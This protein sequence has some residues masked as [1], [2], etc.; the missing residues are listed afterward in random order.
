[1]LARQQAVIEDF[2]LTQKLSPG[3]V[4]HRIGWVGPSRGLLWLSGPGGSCCCRLPLRP[5][6]PLQDGDAGGADTP[7]PPLQVVEPELLAAAGRAEHLTTGTT[8]VPSLQMQIT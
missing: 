1:M 6:Q 3:T 2:D 7:L 5:V 8:V 4:F